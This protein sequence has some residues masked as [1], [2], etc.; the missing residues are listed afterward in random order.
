MLAGRIEAAR[1][2]QLLA[3]SR[4]AMLARPHFVRLH[5]PKDA[6]G[7]MSASFSSNDFHLRLTL[8]DEA[9]RATDQ[10]FTGYEVVRRAA[11]ASY[12]CSWRP[13]LCSSCSRA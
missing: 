4:V 12:R 9:G 13:S 3:S 8:I 6:F 7:S 1:P 2:D 11:R 10:G 5:D